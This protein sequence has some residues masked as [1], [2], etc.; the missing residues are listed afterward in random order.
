MLK[1]WCITLLE[2]RGCGFVFSEITELTKEQNKSLT[3]QIWCKNPCFV[4]KDVRVTA[5]KV[6]RKY[7]WGEQLFVE[8]TPEIVSQHVGEIL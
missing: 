2:N 5:F 7:F 3:G 1:G 8:T 6:D 4:A